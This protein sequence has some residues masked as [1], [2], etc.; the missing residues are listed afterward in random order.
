M[1]KMIPKGRKWSQNVQYGLNGLQWSK[2]VLNGIG[3]INHKFN[4]MAYITSFNLVLVRSKIVQIFT[5]NHL[6]GS[7]ITRSPGLVICIS[8]KMKRSRRIKKITRP[9]FGPMVGSSYYGEFIHEFV[10]ARHTADL[11][12]DDCLLLLH[13]KKSKITRPTIYFQE[14]PC[15]IGNVRVS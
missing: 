15:D 10:K 1:F 7:S 4:R 8:T 9:R 14:R 3:K 2:M 11:W 12:L 6:N 13:L 5:K